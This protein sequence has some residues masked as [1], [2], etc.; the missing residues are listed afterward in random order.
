ML[1]GYI[2]GDILHLCRCFLEPCLR[3]TCGHL[4]ISCGRPIRD[5]TLDLKE[6]IRLVASYDGES[7]A[8]VAL[9]ECRG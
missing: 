2:L 8:H 9:L 4:S 3:L 6:F 1:E 5:D 7:E